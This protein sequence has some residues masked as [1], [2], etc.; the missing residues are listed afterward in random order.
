M[1]FPAAIRSDRAGPPAPAPDT[2]WCLFVDV[3]GTLLEFAPT[4]EAVH[5]DDTLRSLLFNASSSLQGAL[6]L[7]SGRTLDAIDRLFAPQRWPAAGLHGLERR[8]A[9]GQVHRHSAPRESLD[10]ARLSLRDVAARM[11]G[12]LLEDKGLSI[13][14]HY[15]AAPELR[16]SLR[17]IVD[18][19]MA[20]LAP[21]YH[22][23]DGNCVLEI[24]PSAISKADAVRAFMRE[25]PF[26][27][28][29][30]IYVGDDVTDLD[31]FAAAERAGGISVAVGD[32]VEAQVQ[33]PS[34]RSVH[35][36]L[37]DL[38]ERRDPWP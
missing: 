32:R 17:R 7:V 13:A 4:P 10:R 26:A 8:D 11:P 1:P 24:K 38:A 25:A 27:G 14:I 20:E 22:V 29:R 16:P 30:P 21:S 18:E 3:D 2:P 34:P 36:F 6:A 35:C 5:V 15:R 12:V 23:L 31:G 33:L 37:A 28:R 19:V 9:R